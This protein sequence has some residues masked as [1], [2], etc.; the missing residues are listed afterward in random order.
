LR[1][2]RAVGHAQDLGMTFK[3]AGNVIPLDKLKD[4]IYSIEYDIDFFS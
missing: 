2:S 3:Y 4:A 1:K